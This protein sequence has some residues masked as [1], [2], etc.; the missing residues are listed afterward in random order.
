M[1]QEMVSIRRAVALVLLSLPMFGLWM[2]VPEPDDQLSATD[3]Q[4]QPLPTGFRELQL[5]LDL[6]EIQERLSRDPNFFF[7]GE[8]DVSLLKT[9]NESIIECEGTYYIAWGIFQFHEKSLYSITLRFDPALM[10][11]STL[12][13]QL[14]DKYGE[15][16]SLD[17]K[18]VRWE[19]EE[20]LLLLEKPATLKYL[21]LP[22]FN[23][24]RAQRK[25]GED[26]ELRERALL[27]DEL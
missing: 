24:I 16:D 6:E 9:P 3:Y 8:P 20:I 7:R 10:D 23:A 17:P 26:V 2:Q 15:F 5:G 11:F 12:F 18:S 4:P 19:N 27:L 14:L 25:V 1:I 21:Y 13:S 22:T